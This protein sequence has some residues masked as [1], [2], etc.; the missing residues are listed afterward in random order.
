M[1][2]KIIE[3][4]IHKRLYN[5]FDTFQMLYS[6]QFGFREKH[7]TIHALLS[8]T[9]SMKLSIDNGRFGCGIFLHL[10]KAFDTVNHKILLG[11][12]E[13]NGI[14]GNVL[15]WFNSYLTKHHQYVVVNGHKSDSLPITCGVSQGSFLKPLLFLIYMNDLPVVS[16]VLQCYLFADDTNIYYD[17]NDLITL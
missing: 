13:H 2:S 8:L 16:K 1:F 11:K 14:R 12:V 10:Q 17:A 5:F 4:L 6:P 3:K 7:S 15:K 9:E